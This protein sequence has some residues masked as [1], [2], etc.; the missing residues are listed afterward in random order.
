MIP[1]QTHMIPLLTHMIPL[2]THMIWGEDV[3]ELCNALLKV[4]SVEVP[5]PHYAVI[6]RAGSPLHSVLPDDREHL[7]LVEGGV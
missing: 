4:L 7:E 1:L 2:L 6:K 3:Q 5:G